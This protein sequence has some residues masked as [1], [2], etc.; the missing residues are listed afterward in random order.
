MQIRFTVAGIQVGD[1]LSGLSLWVEK[2]PTGPTGYPTGANRRQ[3]R[4][5]PGV[6]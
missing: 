5:E 1:Q 2:F 3:D 4:P 6:G